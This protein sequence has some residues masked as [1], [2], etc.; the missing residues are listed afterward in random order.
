MFDFTDVIVDFI[1]MGMTFFTGL[2]CLVPFIIIPVLMYFRLFRTETDY[3]NE[4][5]EMCTSEDSTSEDSTLEDNIFDYDLSWMKT[6]KTELIFRIIQ[7][8]MMAVLMII[9]LVTMFFGIKADIDFCD[10]LP[11]TLLIGLGMIVVCSII[12]A[13][14]GQ[15]ANI[16]KRARMA[17][18]IVKRFFN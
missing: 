7:Y 4:P 8:T 2:I 16:R 5:E 17:E 12:F 1:I 14:T 18:Y 3:V 9:M 6:G 10:G 15:I 13:A 11:I